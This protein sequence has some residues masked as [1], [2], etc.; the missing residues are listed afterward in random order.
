[1]I[2]HNLTVFPE[3]A[4]VVATAPVISF[5][6][7]KSSRPSP[8][9]PPSDQTRQGPVENS[10]PV[11]GQSLQIE[12]Q[13]SIQILV[14]PS[15]IRIDEAVRLVLGQPLAIVRRIGWINPDVVIPLV[16]VAML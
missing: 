3:P 1:M 8:G 7:K 14:N 9:G 12:I 10:L 4:R 13:D 16:P 6:L 5:A 2:V 11:V 15:V